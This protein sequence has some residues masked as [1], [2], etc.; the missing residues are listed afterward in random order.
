LS[1]PAP[2]GPAGPKP[3]APA[4]TVIGDG[5][6]GTLLALALARRGAAVQLLG[7]PGGTATALSYG[8]LPRG[9]PSRAWTRLERLHGPLGW[10]PSG[11]VW[12]DGRPGPPGVLEALTR[13][14]P[15]PIARVDAPT[16]MAARGP[17]LAAAGVRHRVGQA[18]GLRP[19]SDRR[20]RIDWLAAPA[21]ATDPAEHAEH[22]E[23]TVETVVLAAGAGARALWPALPPRLRHSWA[24]VLLVDASAPANPWLDQARRGRIVQP[25]RW[26][27]PALEAS[28]PNLTEPTWIVDAGV[29]PRGAGVV[30]GQ[31]SLVPPAGPPASPGEA[32][33]PP[34][35]GWMDARLRE[36]LGELD[37]DLARLE[38]PYR[39]VPVSFCSDGQPLVGPVA[40]A[41]GLWTFTGFSAAFSLVPAWA[42]TVSSQLLASASSTLP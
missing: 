15:L 23:L 7:S 39:Q 11:L 20:W 41:P 31:I 8:A 37:P 4:I 25:R 40:D 34:D 24:G 6:A 27:R 42:E 22:L 17:V 14:L 19:T 26:R 10:R 33:E 38:A 32:L 3:D 9:R 13:A 21:A 2:G 16:W 36:G 30:V 1:A 5:L 18:R 12:H 35:P 28:A 29:A